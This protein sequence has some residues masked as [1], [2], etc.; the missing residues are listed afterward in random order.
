MREPSQT[1]DKDTRRI[2]KALLWLKDA[3]LVI[4]D[5]NL[6]RFYDAI[7]RP[8]YK[9]NAPRTLRLTAA[10]REEL[11]KTL[12][13]T[14]KAGL[15][16]LF[17]MFSA[18]AEGTAQRQKTVGADRG[19]EEELILEP[20]STPQRQLEQLIIYYSLIQPE[21][22]LI[23]DLSALL[24]WH[25]SGLGRDMPRALCLV[26]VPAGTRFIPM[27][28]EFENG[29]VA[30]LFDDLA[31]KAGEQLPPYDR[32][33]KAEYWTRLAAL[34]EPAFAA[35]VIEEASGGHG[36]IEWIDFRVL[37]NEA[38]RTAHL[39]LEPRRRYFTGAFAYMVV[40]R[41]VG[42]GIRM[43]GTLKDGPDIN[44]LALYEK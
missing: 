3:P 42:H 19:I 7:V 17:G 11:Q 12:G 26:D 43:V 40:R 37:L 39:H 22:L 35:E 20:I 8:A 27:A 30:R 14:V 23:G 1:E 28:A 13:A 44:V 33:R 41:S 10:Q 38:A 15:S 16:G 5:E 29:K 36:K 25:E 31:R 6:A 18:E 21:R 34:A 4:D 32:D 24:Q 2:R 9:E